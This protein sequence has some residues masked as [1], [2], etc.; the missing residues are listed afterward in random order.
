MEVDRA[1]ERVDPIESHSNNKFQ[2]LRKIESLF[3]TE[4]TQIICSKP[5]IIPSAWEEIVT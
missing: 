3:M 5:D 1:A 2:L 4:E